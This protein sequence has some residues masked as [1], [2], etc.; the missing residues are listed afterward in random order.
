[1][2]FPIPSPT[3]ENQLRHARDWL[4]HVNCGRIGAATPPPSPET[5]ASW[6]RMEAV[7]L[8]TRRAPRGMHWVLRGDG[9]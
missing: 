4:S 7:V 2:P 8:G 5:V 9:R 6:E 1:M 3:D